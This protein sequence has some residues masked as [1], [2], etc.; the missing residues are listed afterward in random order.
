MYNI[1]ILIPVFN[2][3]EYTKRCIAQL[4]EFRIDPELQHSCLSI[5][6]IDDGSSDGT[7][8]WVRK[9][10][11]EVHLL[12][13][14]GT[15]WWSGG[16]NMGAKYAIETLKA[17]FLLLWNN[18]IQ[19]A[20]DYFKKL[21]LL[22]P[23]LAKDTVVGSKVY[24]AIGSDIIWAFGGYFNA[25]TGTNYMIGTRQKDGEAYMSARE[26]DWIPGMGTMFPVAVVQ[27]IGFW[28]DE[29]FPQYYG[30]SDYTLRAKKAGYHNIVYPQLRIWNDNS[31]T[32]LTHQGS[33]RGLCRT[34]TD[35]KSSSKLST[36]IRFYRLH[37]TSPLAYQRLIAHYFKMIGGFFKWKILAMF[38]MKKKR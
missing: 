27:K 13:G 17:D 29:D 26:V 6:L 10:H 4:S 32:G 15:L 2:K 22:L 28:N 18:D 12:E 1:A 8:E 34:L 14:D 3:L 38:G 30:D 16:I 37:A 24:E 33:F 23:D 5:V 9:Q 7:S 25:K 20:A 11:P 19:V 31:S 35:M 36:N 21:D